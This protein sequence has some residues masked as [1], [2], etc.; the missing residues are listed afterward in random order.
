MGDRP[1]TAD[2]ALGEKLFGSSLNWAA[3]LKAE[4]RKWKEGLVLCR[5]EKRLLEGVDSGGESW[6]ALAL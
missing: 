3:F 6:C 5:Q 2:P 4:C 1:Y